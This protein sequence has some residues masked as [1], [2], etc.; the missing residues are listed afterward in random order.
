MCIR[1]RLIGVGI[2]AFIHNW[3]PEDF[4]VKTLGTGN[5]FGVIIATIVG[6]MCIRDSL[7]V[8]AYSYF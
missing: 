4:I 6:K 2:G 3:I 7:L 8:I 5:P 1:D